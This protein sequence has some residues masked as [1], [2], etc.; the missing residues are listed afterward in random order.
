VLAGGGLKLPDAGA[1]AR[2]EVGGELQ[3]AEL[4]L[5]EPSVIVQEA[6]ADVTGDGAADTVLLVGHKEA[7]S[8][9][10]W[11]EMWVVVQEGRTGAFTKISPGPVAG[12]YGGELSLCDFTGD[13]AAEILVGLPTGDSGGMTLY[14]V[15]SDRGGSPEVLW[16]QESLSRGAGFSTEFRDGFVLS[17]FNHELKRRL[18]IA[19][20]GSKAAAIEA[21][22]YS[23]DGRTL[24]EA[25]AMVN[26]YFLMQPR[27]SERAGVC[28]L[29]GFQ[30]I[31]GLRGA[32]TLGRIRSV[33]R[34]EEGGWRLVDVEARSRALVWAGEYAS[35]RGGNETKLS[36]RADH[37][38]ELVQSAA[39]QGPDSRAGRWE[40]SD[41][42]AKVSFPS[43]DGQAGEDAF[44]AEMRGDVL[45][46]RAPGAA[47]V[48]LERTAGEPKAAPA[49]DEGKEQ[50]FRGTLISGPEAS[51]LTPCGSDERI[52]V[53]DETG[54]LWGIYGRFAASPYDPVFVE[55]RG[56]SGP[57]PA[58]GPGQEYG[59]QI[60]VTAVRRAAKEGL[61]C[62][63]D[64]TGI[65]FKAR[66]NEP[67]WNVT[68]G[69]DGITFFDI[70]R[71][72]IKF[73]YTAPARAPGRWIYYTTAAEKGKHWLLI[74]ID[75][76]PCTDS[77]TG[78]YSSFSADVLIDGQRYTGC[79][80]SGAALEE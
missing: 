21:G 55:V 74:V 42:T 44:A 17:V 64:L 50:T 16:D 51:V 53:T 40:A 54:K 66:G 37:S 4:D 77:A 75:E 76:K 49:P 36:L 1:A 80:T 20:E 46:L 27:G 7:P 58:E 60:V 5:P 10:Y 68:V 32:D 56:R 8:E 3:A 63:E 19:L 18:E 30:W 43:V 12:G 24:K 69:E 59:R 15:L 11:R 41:G 70:S 25:S 73:R 78:E 47:E 45:T 6:E 39:G 22:I 62:D 33:W 61:G 34:W 52:W 23:A 2:Y 13:G 31:G 79:A 9:S 38:A 14:S 29:V 28:D 67:F 65:E 57:P 72:Q 71:L 35:G 26:P 48:T